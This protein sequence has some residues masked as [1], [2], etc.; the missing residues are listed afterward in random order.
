MSLPSPFVLLTSLQ[1]C[2]HYSYLSAFALVWSSP[3]SGVLLSLIT[4]WQNHLLFP[5][6][7]VGFSVCQ[8]ICCKCVFLDKKTQNVTVSVTWL[9]PGWTLSHVSQ[10]PATLLYLQLLW[11]VSPSC[12]LD[13]FKKTSVGVEQ[14]LIDGYKAF[15][16]KSYLL[17]NNRLNPILVNSL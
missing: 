17:N 16:L 4:T 13:C 6:V 7:S 11:C 5:S 15:G 8:H 1:S 2:L 3:Q 12:G 14:L 9:T 10:S